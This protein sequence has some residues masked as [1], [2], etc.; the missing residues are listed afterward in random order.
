MTDEPTWRAQETLRPAGEAAPTAHPILADELVAAEPDAAAGAAAPARRGSGAMLLLAASLVLIA[1]NLRCAIASIGPVLPDVIRTTG[2]SPGGASALTTLPSLC[3]GLFGPIAPA[4]TRRLGTERTLLA[5]LAAMVVGIAA[6]GLGDAAALFGGQILAC[7][8]IGIINV[9]LPGLVKRDFPAHAAIMTGCYVMA[10]CVG[11]AAAAGATVPLARQLGGSWAAALAFWAV[12]VVLAAALWGLQLRAPEHPG[13]R[14]VAR[15]RGLW[16]DP[17][18]WQVTLFMGLQSAFAYI[19]F[20]WLAPILRDRGLDPVEAGL[21]VSASILA[22][23]AAS[24]V[25]PSL[26]TI[27]RDQRVAAAISSLVCLGAFLACVFGP[28]AWIWAWS[29]L[30]GLSEGALFAIAL[31]LIVLRAPDA[32]VAAQLSGMSQGVGYILA[33]AGPLWVGL[34]HGWTGDWHAL[35][36]LSLVLG[37]AMTASG[38]GAGRDLHVQ[39]VAIE[40]EPKPR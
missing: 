13:A 5:I 25:A 29:I 32:H 34:L 31:M 33:S 39:A 3:F 10:L 8:G 35:L 22:Q 9:L 15:V 20:G 12:P 14:H 23:A 4:F 7:A 21:V 2:L 16:T 26:S 18:A 19:V 6:R 30:L 27:G 36:W 40:P 38:I 28:L 37:A 1:F 17:L 24:L 11:A